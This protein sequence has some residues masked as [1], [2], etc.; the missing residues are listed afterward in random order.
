[1]A[2]DGSLPYRSFLLAGPAH[3]PRLAELATNLAHE[4]NP[5]LAVIGL[6]AENAL[7]D[8]RHGNAEDAVL[9]LKGIVFQVHS[10]AGTIEKL[11]RFAR[12]GQPGAPPAPVSLNE[13][14]TCLAHELNPPMAIIGLS[15]GTALRDLR[16]GNAKDTV[17]RLKGIVV[18]VH[19]AVG[20]IEKLGRFA[21]GGQSGAPPAPMPLDEAVANAP[22]PA[23]RGRRKQRSRLRRRSA[24]PR[25]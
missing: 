20:I 16:D 3:F 21:R 17:R 24:T 13:M 18:Q 9:R 8:V 25:R 7:R 12:A 23:G 6:C 14:T 11:R 10:A 1:M 2:E 15:A 19:R 4:L 5:V 22:P